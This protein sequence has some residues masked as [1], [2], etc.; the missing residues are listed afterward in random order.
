MKVALN[1][2]R[3]QIVNDIGFSSD[4][5]QTNKGEESVDHIEQCS[6]GVIAIQ[7]SSL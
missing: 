7:E 6:Q 5:Q 4:R 3:I 2:H 1:R